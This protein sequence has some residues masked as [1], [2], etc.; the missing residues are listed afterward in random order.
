M[1]G[2]FNSEGV[3]G[4]LLNRALH[5]QYRTVYAYD[6]TTRYGVVLPPLADSS[7]LRRQDSGV[8]LE[9]EFK[10][11]AADLGQGVDA[12][13]LALQFL[14]MAVFGRGGAL[15]TYVLTLDGEW[16]WTETGV[17]FA[18]DLLSKHTMHA[19]V[20]RVVAFS[21]EFFVKRIGQCREG[22]KGCEGSE[23]QDEDDCGRRRCWRRRREAECDEE[24][25][26]EVEDPSQYE[27]VI[28]NSSGKHF[29]M[30]SY[31]NTE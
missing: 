13:A 26:D 12:R 22:A 11:A 31:S 9:D 1:L 4:T 5:K 15:C 16:R 10:V 24:Q 18:V 23:Y 21:G 3:R 14:R 29:N 27:L 2:M 20:S 19:D 30:V 7:S 8:V 17:E 25:E 6:K 28:D